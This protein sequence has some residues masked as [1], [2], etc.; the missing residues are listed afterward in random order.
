MYG[1][2]MIDEVTSENVFDVEVYAYENGRD[3]S[4]NNHC[5]WTR[6]EAWECFLESHD[7]DLAA[8]LSSNMCRRAFRLGWEGSEL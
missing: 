2:T 5:G 6:A 7:G 8:Q 4:V 3:S 1:E